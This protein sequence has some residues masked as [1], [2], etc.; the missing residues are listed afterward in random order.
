MP[1]S[2]LAESGYHQ[3]PEVVFDPSYPEV[4]H[5]Y[6]SDPEAVT[7]NHTSYPELAP[8]PVPASLDQHGEYVKGAAA[9]QPARA[10]GFPLSRKW[11]ITL[12]IA[13]L[14][15]TIAAVVGGVIGSKSRSSEAADGGGSGATTG[16]SAAT[17]ATATTATP[18]GTV[19]TTTSV[20]N[21]VPATIAA[22]DTTSG[23]GPA[24]QVFYQT[25]DSTDIQ[26]TVYTT[27][28]NFNTTNKLVLQNTPSLNVPLAVIS[29]Y[30]SSDNSLVRLFY[31][32]TSGTTTGIAQ[33]DISCEK[34]S[35]TCVVSAESTITTN[36]T[37][38]VHAQSGIA[39]VWLGT[40][41][42]ANRVYYQTVNGDIVELDGDNEA[43][44]GWVDKTIGGNAALGSHLAAI[45]APGPNISILYADSESGLPTEIAYSGGWQSRK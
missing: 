22:L 40:T 43:T 4:V 15:V 13:A 9:T 21:R 11:I 45:F 10:H 30:D 35:G 34:G 36:V 38:V 42:E 5:N 19:A 41:A 28:A 37:H 33:A 3:L 31:I 24:I 12:G 14:V 25:D 29:R 7:R 26:Y 6:S 23:Q 39:A 1:L 44:T 27:G 32:S 16:P 8:S 18:S 17:P 2:P 20:A